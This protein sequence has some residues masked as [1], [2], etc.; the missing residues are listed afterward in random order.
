[1]T[2]SIFPFDPNLEVRDELVSIH[3]ISPFI[4][5]CSSARCHM[6]SSHLSQS[7]TV[8]HG[9]EKIIQTGLEQQ[10]GENVLNVKI[11]DDVK[12]VKVIPRYHSIDVNGVNKRVET[13]LITENLKTGEIDYVLIPYYH[14]LHQYFGFE[15]VKDEDYISSLRSGDILYKDTV[16]ATSPTIDKNNGYKF[17][18]NANVCLINLP[19]T[20]EDGVVISKRLSEKM[21]YTIFEERHVEFGAEDFPLNL[22]GDHNTY[23]PFPDIG[24]KINQDSVLMALRKYETSMS[25]ALISIQDVREFNPLFDKAIYV[26]GQGEDIE[27]MGEKHSSGEI[28]DIKVWTNPKYK[29]EIYTGVTGDIERYSNALINYYKSI[30]DI[31][32][33]IKKEHYIRYKDNNV[34]ISEKFHRLVVEALAIVNPDNKKLGYSFKNEV[35]DLVRVSFVIKYTVKVSTGHKLSDFSGSKGVVVQVR[36]NEDMP[37]TMIN[38]EKVFADVVMDPSSLVS[39]MNVGRIYEHYFNAMSRKT[40][41]EI[42]KAMGGIKSIDQYKVSELEAG[43]NILMGLLELIGTEQFI[44]YNKIK[45]IEVKKHILEECINKEVYIIYRVSSKKRPYQIVMDSRGTIYQPEVTKVHINGENGKVFTT[46]DDIMIAPI[47]TILLS[48]TS[49]SFL[50]VAGAKLN[51]FG[52]PIGVGSATRNYT[53]WRSSPTKILSETETRLYTSY[54]SRTAIAELKNRAN[55]IDTHMAIYNNILNADTPTNIESV[56]DREKYGYED[57]S[58]MELINNIFNCAGIEIKY[59]PEK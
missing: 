12:I 2:E 11:E 24:D 14:K 59:I 10:F 30:L 48:K 6:A 41:Y 21:A 46:K 7:L 47:Y 33:E 19:E 9:D 16:L 5:E 50:S 56:Y 20:T 44:E 38:G 32:N 55:N 4:R 39:R 31:Y 26:K 42:R 53:P 58:A 43:W 52:F 22:Y 17:G 40:Q 27:I 49:D 23:K 45:D 29:K 37:Y 28:V 36:E 1:M 18:V 54:V 51:H 15:Y 25:P 34:P 57:D 8:L 13:L 3:A 35:I